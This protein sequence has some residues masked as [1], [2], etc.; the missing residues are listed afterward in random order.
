M[1]EAGWAVVQPVLDVWAALPARDFP[2]YAAGSWGP[3][4]ADEL[5]HREGREWRDP[6]CYPTRPARAN[7]GVR[8]QTPA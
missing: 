2:N 6:A 5:L 8:E 1:V 7:V 3:A 4:Q